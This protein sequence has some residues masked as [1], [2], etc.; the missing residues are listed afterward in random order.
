ME[1]ITGIGIDRNDAR[2]W[3]QPRCADYSSPVFDVPKKRFVP[4]RRE[5]WRQHR[6]KLRQAARIEPLQYLYC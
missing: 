1:R 2:A 5:G 6:R 4:Q 3:S